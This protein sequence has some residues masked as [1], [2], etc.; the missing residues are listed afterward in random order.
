M[1]EVELKNFVRDVL[2]EIAEGVRS[3]N[4][5]LKD[6]QKNQYEVF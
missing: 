1:A 4:G 2:I 5:R 6:P 3:A